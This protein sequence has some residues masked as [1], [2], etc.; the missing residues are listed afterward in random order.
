VDGIVAVNAAL[1]GLPLFTC[2]LK[3]ELK[4]SAER[5]PFYSH[6]AETECENCSV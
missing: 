5:I 1:V 3:A 4:P 6:L 2:S